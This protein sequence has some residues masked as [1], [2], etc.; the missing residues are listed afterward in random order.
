[1]QQGVV[2][3]LDD[4]G[5]ARGGEVQLHARRPPRQREVDRERRHIVPPLERTHVG[6]PRVLGASATVGR[7]EVVRLG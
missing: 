1:M 5:V 2:V 6:A 4:V 7:L 3:A